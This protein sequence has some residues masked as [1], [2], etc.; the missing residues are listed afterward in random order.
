MF[1]TVILI[2]KNGEIQHLNFK[3]I[4]IRILTII[5]MFFYNENYYQKRV[6]VV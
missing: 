5:S 4:K 3:L 1:L 6:N 2:I